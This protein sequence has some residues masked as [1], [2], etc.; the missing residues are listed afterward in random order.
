MIPV[1]ACGT[2]PAYFIIIASIVV[3]APSWISAVAL[4]ASVCH[5]VAARKPASTRCL[6]AWTTIVAI[7]VSGQMAVLAQI[8]WLNS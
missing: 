7:G 1:L 5:R 2:Y 6:I 4:F 8:G 3:F